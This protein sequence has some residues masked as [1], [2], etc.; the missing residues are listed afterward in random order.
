M[1]VVLPHNARSFREHDEF[2]FLDAL[3]AELDFATPALPDSG[4]ANAT[5]RLRSLKAAIDRHDPDY[6]FIPSADLLIH[7]TAVWRV[8]PWARP[9]RKPVI[10]G[11]VHGCRFVYSDGDAKRALKNAMSLRLLVA[12]PTES[13]KLLNHDAVEHLQKVV[14]RLA[15]R[16]ELF[17][18]IVESHTPLSK[19]DA[20]KMW[21]LPEDARIAGCVGQ[22]SER[23]G[24]DLLL[25]AFA[26]LSFR[27]HD[28]LLLVGQLSAV[29]ERMIATEY[30]SLMKQ[31]RLIVCNRF[32]AQAEMTAAICA[33]DLVCT[34]YRAQYDVASIILSASSLH[35]PVLSS[36]SRW[37]LATV[38]S[39]GLGTTCNVFDTQAFAAAIG[40]GL[41]AAPSFQPSAISRRLAAYHAPRNFAAHVTRKPREMLGLPASEDVRPWS[42]VLNSGA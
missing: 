30:S 29:I 3:G 28:H 13:I 9:R 20:R 12:A 39:L 19:S 27:S 42:A 15:S 18:C 41:D 6:V 34:P 2:R 22:L 37:P 40:Q 33:M 32:V 5:G 7:A 24:I 4:V 35:R 31:G 23:K 8:F 25:R 11:I 26:A 21:N 17:P 38:K 16:F 1:T 36:E 14:P 10:D